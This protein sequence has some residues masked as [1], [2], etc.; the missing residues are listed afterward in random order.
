MPGGRSLRPVTVGGELSGDRIEMPE[1]AGPGRESGA[2]RPVSERPRLRPD[3][4]LV[5]Q[6]Y[7]GEQSYIVKDPTT[8]KYF[9][10]RPLEVMVMQA[11]DGQR[12][13]A[14][15]AVAL[16]GAG[17]PASARARS[18]SSPKSS[19]RWGWCER[20][21]RERSVLLVE[22]LRAQRRTRLR[23]GPFRAIS[24]GC[25]GPWGTRTSS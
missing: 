25:A 8:R 15:A 1:R 18:A 14:E 6:S 13:A 9:R 22:R 21:L 17:T 2:G 10:F 4:V 23:R 16:A 7:R 11:L 3:L 24:S 19:R 20:T 12:S 5:E